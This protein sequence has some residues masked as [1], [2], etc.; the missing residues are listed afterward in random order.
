MSGSERAAIAIRTFLFVD[1]RGYTRFTTEHGDTAALHLV[2]K[3]DAVARKAFGA[4]HGEVAG[5]AGDE[6]VAV[7]ASARDALRAALQL[8]A[9][10]A[11]EVSMDP[12]LPQVGIG[13]DAGEAKPLREAAAPP[14]L[15]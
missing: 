9:S 12:K 5:R 7:F 15:R 4:W 10:F 14:K 1:I 2:E 11:E 3:F 13:L 8:Q 6:L